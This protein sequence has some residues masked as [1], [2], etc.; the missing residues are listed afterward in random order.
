[1]GVHYSD[2]GMHTTRYWANDSL[3]KLTGL[4][5]GFVW[6]DPIEK[7][8]EAIQKWKSWWEQNKVNYDLRSDNR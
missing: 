7:R 2:M 1:V 5:V 3:K 8:N 6:N 4:D